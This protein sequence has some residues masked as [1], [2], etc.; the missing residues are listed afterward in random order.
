MMYTYNMQM[1]PEKWH[2]LYYEDNKGRS[3]IYKFI[4]KRKVREKAKILALL[5]IY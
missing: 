1:K 2:V 3:E 4:E 5:D